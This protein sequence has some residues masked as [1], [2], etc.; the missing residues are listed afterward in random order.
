[1]IFRIF[2]NLKMVT[3]IIFLDM[4]VPASI[5]GRCGINQG[6]LISSGLLVLAGAVV[7]GLAG[8]RTVLLGLVVEVAALVPLVM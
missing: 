4:L 1:L 5:L 6:A 2:Q 8:A 3:L 7:E